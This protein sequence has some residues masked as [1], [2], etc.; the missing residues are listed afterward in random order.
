[1]R[2]AAQRGLVGGGLGRRHIGPMAALGASGYWKRHRRFALDDDPPASLRE[3]LEAVWA[4]LFGTTGADRL[5]DGFATPTWEL[6]DKESFRELGPLA[7]RVAAE[8]AASDLSDFLLAARDSMEGDPQTVS[9]IF[10]EAARLSN[11]E[12]LARLEAEDPFPE[13]LLH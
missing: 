3:R 11:S 8:L 2:P 9:M 12:P 13:V 1:M 5:R 4:E 6:H 10:N 7:A